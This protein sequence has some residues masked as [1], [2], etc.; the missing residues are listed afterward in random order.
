MRRVAD[1][2]HPATMP[3]RN[4]WEVVRVVARQ[5]EPA[6]PDERGGRWSVIVEQAG[7]P[8]MPAVVGC[9]RPLVAPISARGA[10][11][12]QTMSPS[13]ACCAPKNA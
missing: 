13:G 2:D 9:R 7:Q 12:N 11:T 8:G 5:L 1:D 3:D 10:L 4:M 6:G